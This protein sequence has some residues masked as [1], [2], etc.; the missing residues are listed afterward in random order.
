MRKIFILLIPVLFTAQACNFLFGDLYGNQGT[1]PKG[2]FISLDSGSTW[3]AGKQLGSKADFYTA[4]ANDIFIE[5]G[6]S[7]NA[8]AATITNGVFASDS[9][10]KHWGQLLPDF[11]AY[12]TFINPGNGNEIMAAGARGGLASIL[13]SID[14]GNTWTQIYNEPAG[15]AAV[16]SLVYS[17]A[18]SQQ[19]YAGL[20]TGTALKSGDFGNT[21]NAITNFESS[22]ADI[23]ITRDGRTVFYL[24]TLEGVTRTVDGG[25]TWTE[26]DLPREP[27]A[28]T[29]Y[30]DIYIDQKDST[31]YVGTNIGLYRST[32]AGAN[33]QKLK[34]PATSKISDVTAVE[35][36][37][38]KATQ[39]FAAIGFTVYR[40]DDR[41]ISWQT[42]ALPTG[43][44]I[45]SI[46]RDPVE[47]NRIYAGLR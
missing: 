1:G 27:S 30:N 42:V 45:S 19:L 22:V 9:S 11:A 34:L 3:E 15:R 38:Q 40:S 43:R 2:V 13:K 47:P 28:P 39:I 6:R 23:A 44:I 37:P 46:A 33:W 18:N 17:P 8:L 10:G 36:N 26:I 4:G 7:N 14:R 32:D 20:S 5:P 25:V 24:T 35:V 41:G 21:W 29:R 31:L 12:A 16:T